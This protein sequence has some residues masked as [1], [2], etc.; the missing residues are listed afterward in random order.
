MLG[1][2]IQ[3]L[4]TWML[5]VAKAPMLAMLDP[6]NRIYWP[7]LGMALALG[8]WIAA[9]SSSKPLRLN[10]R[11]VWRTLKADVFWFALSSVMRLWS[12]GWQNAWTLALSIGVV[13]A[14]ADL[15]GSLHTSGWLDARAWPS[16]CIT[17]LYSGVLFGAW[18]ASRYVLHRMM[19]GVP[20]LWRFHRVHHSAEVLH[21]WTLHRTHPVEVLLY[22]L[23]G[24]VVTGSVA[25]LF[26]LLFGAKAQ[27]W[28][29]Q[30]VH[31]LGFV[32]NFLGGNLRHS[33]IWLAY[34]RWERWLV[35]PAQHQW[36][37]SQQ[38][39]RQRQNLGTWLA[40]WDRLWGT[41]Q[42]VP[43][44]RPADFAVG[45]T[46]DALEEAPRKRAITGVW[47]ALWE[48]FGDM[49]MDMWTWMMR[50]KSQVHRMR[51]LAWF[52][53]L[54]ALAS[55]FV[56]NRILAAEPAEADMVLVEPF[57]EI[58]ESDG[59][60][61]AEV[62]GKLAHSESANGESADFVVDV[63]SIVGQRFLDTDRIAG[64]A[65]SV[66]EKELGEFEDDDAHRLLLRLPGV[67][68]RSEEG[69]G[70]R[71]N[72]GLR[73][74]SADRSAKITLT[75]DGILLGPAPYSAPAAY[76]FPLMTRL[77]GMDVFK[78]PGT[79]VHGPSTV[80]GAIDLQT[81]S[82][83][84]AGTYITGLDLAV[85]QRRAR[86]MHGFW[87]MAGKHL[88][89]LLE[90]VHLEH[91]GFKDLDGGGPTGFDKNELM[92]KMRYQR[93][94]QA[95]FY[96]QFDLKLGFADERSHET[97]LGLADTD[98]AAT[99]YRRYAASQKG[100]MS[101]W[102][103]QIEARYL[104]AAGD[105]WDLE[106][107]AYRHDFFRTWTRLNRIG[108]SLS[109]SD[110][111]RERGGQGDVFLNVLRGI[112]DSE[113]IDQELHVGS[114]RRR[115]VSQG[116]F[117]TA[118]LQALWG[119]VSQDLRMGLRL[120]HDQIHRDHSEEAH[121]MRSGMLQASGAAPVQVADN[122]GQALALAAHIVDEIRWRKLLISPSFRM[123]SIWTQFDDRLQAGANGN[124]EPWQHQ[125]GLMPG[126]G[127]HMQTTP[128]L[129]VLAGVYRGFGPVSPGQAVGVQPESSVNYELGL[130]S[131]L[132]SGA[133]NSDN[134]AA[135][136]P[137]GWRS[138]LV[139]FFNDYGNLSAECT[140]STGCDAAAIGSQSNAGAVHVYGLEAE[141]AWDWSWMQGWQLSTT[142][143][144]T[145]T[146]SS[147]Q[148]DFLSSNPQLGQVRTGDA[149]PYIPVHQG[150]GQMQISW[151]GPVQ[152]WGGRFMG[153]HLRVSGHAIG[154]M[155]DLPGQGEIAPEGKVPGRFLMDVLL[156]TRP[157]QSL[158]LYLSMRN[159]LNSAQLV[160]RR[161][162]GA[163]P[164]Q[165]F[166]AMVGI[167]WTPDAR[168]WGK[169]QN[170]MDRR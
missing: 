71:P 143:N 114:N 52:L 7:S 99:P 102:R 69:F 31:A 89:V 57:V 33:S 94:T 55:M 119:E 53:G 28:Q 17:A 120:H 79:L 12:Q 78:G 23:R 122:R 101:W 109:L 15:G 134:T 22:S 9:R 58:E 145:L 95:G 153:W 26:F 150:H 163:R 133:Q 91:G 63:V 104:L 151:Q 44:T 115:F 139:G 48:P 16:W 110:I 129:G 77:V 140:F 162:F 131:D 96:H 137:W 81:R 117:G 68:V 107:G 111:L 66:D 34:G 45:L 1:I 13:R 24:I 29:I 121:V 6:H 158:E 65:H 90:G 118:H 3:T 165:P 54:A 159:I 164:G 82:V 67:Y 27:V 147:F 61:P 14:W 149:L 42:P 169:P 75:E 20:W 105:A 141:S 51:V 103:T 146:A 152:V 62:D 19:H 87:G 106:L 8:L 142:L 72:I 25:G 154:A 136:S 80:G 73:G 144:Y 112:E 50:Q 138:S 170:A 70:L 135:K 127:V 38:R 10:S 35:S 132:R 39:E 157:L 84:Q 161:P 128:W 47:R 85:G 166:Q 2:E 5:R 126:L 160:S 98:F 88:G 41:W 124:A 49:G 123:E 116:L 64:A 86:K 37:H 56:E 32:F 108:N 83:P 167:K 11:V 59:A 40:C 100:L 155:R 60:K 156:G 93:S 46:I 4:Q 76:F 43:K 36:H 97:Y 168:G 92:G 148:S 125:L 74:V 130:R 113:G 18:D 30:G 21:P